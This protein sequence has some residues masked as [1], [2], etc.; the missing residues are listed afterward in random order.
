M[1]ERGLAQEFDIKPLDDPNSIQINILD[2][3]T[4]PKHIRGDYE[5]RRALASVILDPDMRKSF[6]SIARYENIY[7]LDKTGYRFFKFRFDPPPLDQVTLSVRG[8]YDES[9]NAIF[10][11]EIHG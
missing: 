2:S 11:Y 7:G 8:H 9:I 6:E 4:L 3:C 1:I 5:L 10:V